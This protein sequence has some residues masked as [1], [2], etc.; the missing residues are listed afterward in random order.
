MNYLITS[1]RAIS[2]PALP[3]ERP[4]FEPHRTNIKR[5]TKEI[6]YRQSVRPAGLYS[7]MHDHWMDIIMAIFAA[8]VNRFI[9]TN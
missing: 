3:Q 2:T 8:L 4:L 5:C 6:L 7:H 9:S 1:L